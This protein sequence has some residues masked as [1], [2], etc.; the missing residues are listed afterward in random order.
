MQKLLPDQTG[1]QIL[2][3]RHRYTI[4]KDREEDATVTISNK[5]VGGEG[6]IFEKTHNWDGIDGNTK[7][8]FDIVPTSLGSLW[9]DGSIHTTGGELS[10]IKIQ[11]SYQFDPCFIPLSNPECEGFKDALYQYLLDNDL[12]NNE[13]ALDD[14]Y[15]QE[16]AE[17]KADQEEE[18]IEEA[19]EEEVEE[20]EEITTEQVLSITGKAAEVVD[21]VKQQE[22]MAALIGDTTAFDTYTKLELNGGVYNE[23]LVMEGGELKG[24]FREYR[25]MSSSLAFDKIFKSQ[26][27]K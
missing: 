20:E 9:G 24:N 13:P 16:W 11:Y 18:E 19:K 23:V 4:T 2:A 1:L 22:M 21:T 14:P 7:V 27:N 12:L 5:R 15:Y 6:N 10:D 26:F 25:E 3:V 17:Y 8:G